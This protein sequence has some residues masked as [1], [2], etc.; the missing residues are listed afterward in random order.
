ME[1]FSEPS[2]TVTPNKSNSSTKKDV[3]KKIRNVKVSFFHFGKTDTQIIGYM[4]SGSTYDAKHYIESTLNA[5][6]WVSKSTCDVFHKRVKEMNK[7]I[8]EFII[9]QS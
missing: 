2:K 6:H 9:S 8:L 4:I 5:P 3:P 1:K 7:L